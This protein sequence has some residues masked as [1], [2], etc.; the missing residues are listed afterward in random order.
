MCAEIDALFIAYFLANDNVSEGYN[1]TFLG[2]VLF[3]C[4]T[5]AIIRI[6]VMKMATSAFVNVFPEF[7]LP[8]STI[9]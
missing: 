4:I 7:G 1:G 3:S 9:N 2:M 6:N 8:A 5:M